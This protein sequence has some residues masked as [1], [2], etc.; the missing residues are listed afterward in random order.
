[1][2]VISPAPITR[3]AENGTCYTDFIGYIDYH[4]LYG[5]IDVCLFLFMISFTILTFFLFWKKSNS[6]KRLLFALVGY[7]MIII[8]CIKS[9]YELN[10]KPFV[11][12][13]FSEIVVSILYI[14]CAVLF[15]LLGNENFKVNVRK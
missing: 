3:Q 15:L 13:N 14:A 12:M 1:M 8:L 4:N 9:L 2:S 11:A 5:V 7:V 10:T 6:R